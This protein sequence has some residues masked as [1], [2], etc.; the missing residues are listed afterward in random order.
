MKQKK[1]MHLAYCELLKISSLFLLCLF[2]K[3]NR[4][5]VYL[6]VHFVFDMFICYIKD[7][8]GLD[9]MVVRFTTTCAII[10]YHH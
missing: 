10:A 2:R 5:K 3:R 4:Y 1:T 8:H 6:Q 7:C 9:R